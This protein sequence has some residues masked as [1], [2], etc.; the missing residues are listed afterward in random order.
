MRSAT[1]ATVSGECPRVPHLLLWSLVWRAL[2]PRHGVG[3]LSGYDFSF[4][5]LIALDFLP[6]PVHLGSPLFIWSQLLLSFLCLLAIQLLVSRSRIWLRSSQL[7]LRPTHNPCHL[8]TFYFLLKLAFRHRRNLF[9]I[10]LIGRGLPVGRAVWDNHIKWVQQH[11]LWLL[12]QPVIDWNAGD[13]KNAVWINQKVEA[14]PPMFVLKYA[15]VFS[16]W[17]DVRSFV[18]EMRLNAR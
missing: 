16:N 15:A 11:R 6:A 3:A 14:L 2:S 9:P 18:L 17:L 4:A 7:Q 12:Y 10:L 1:F 13:N 5:L 8:Q